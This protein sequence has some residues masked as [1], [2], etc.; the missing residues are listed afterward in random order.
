MVDDEAHRSGSKSCAR[1]R[2]LPWLWSKIERPEPSAQP[3]Q[4]F[5][6]DNIIAASSRSYGCRRV[7]ACVRVRR[8]RVTAD[9]VPAVLSIRARR[10]SEPADDNYA[11]SV[12]MHGTP[13]M[14]GAS[15]SQRSR[16]GSKLVFVPVLESGHGFRDKSLKTFVSGGRTGTKCP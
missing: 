8:G 12:A 9:P 14:L 4:G 16:P 3:G 6:L 7:Q 5:G 15:R 11:M 10:T 2:M 13:R 1:M